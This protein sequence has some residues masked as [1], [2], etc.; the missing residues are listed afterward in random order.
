LKRVNIYIIGIFVFITNYFH[1]IVYY[2]QIITIFQI[3]AL[4]YNHQ[5]YNN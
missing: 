2:A 4:Y 5:G 3:V 1:F